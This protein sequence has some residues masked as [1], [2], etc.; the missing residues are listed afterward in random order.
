MRTFLSSSVPKTKMKKPF[1]DINETND[2]VTPS[3]I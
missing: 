3:F 2:I 1:E